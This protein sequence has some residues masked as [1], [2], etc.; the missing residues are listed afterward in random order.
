MWGTCWGC[1]C[2]TSFCEKSIFLR[3]DSIHNPP[4]K[5]CLDGLLRWL[6][7]QDPFV[8]LLF[9]A[10]HITCSRLPSEIAGIEHN[11]TSMLRRPT[12][13]W[14]TMILD[15]QGHEF[16]LFCPPPL[17]RT[18][19]AAFL[20]SQKTRI[21]G[22]VDNHLLDNSLV[23]QDKEK[24]EKGRWHASRSGETCT[25]RSKI[26]HDFVGKLE[27]QRKKNNVF[28]SSSCAQHNN[29]TTKRRQKEGK[30]E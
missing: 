10:R 27:V 28:T 6:N 13:C 2:V 29:Q 23:I 4:K 12:H 7:I 15:L 18:I 22:R 20:R 9:F 17:G 11:T 26:H 24:K 30:T 3:V 25:R 21:H 19:Y 16:H 14:W 8:F 1:N 5:P